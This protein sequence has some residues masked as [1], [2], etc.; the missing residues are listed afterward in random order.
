MTDNSLASTTPRSRAL[1]YVAGAYLFAFGVASAVAGA[2]PGL[3]PL[4]TVFAADVAA[5]VLVFAFS[6]TFSNSSFYD[7]FWSVAPMLIA[8]YLVTRSAL[9]WSPRAI[10]VVALVCFW[11]LRL[12]AN[13]VGG[14]EGL[15]HEDWRYVEI[16][17]KAGKAQWVASFFAIHFFPTCMVFLGC[18][19]LFPALVAPRAGLGWID[20]LAAA[21]TLGATLVEMIAD[22]QLHRFTAACKPGEIMDRG[23]WRYS[24]HPNYFG[25]ISFWWGLWL[26]GVAADP[27]QALWTFAGPGAMTCLFVFASVPMLDKRSAERRPGY[28]EHMKR[29]SALVP[30]FPRKG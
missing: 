2:A 18:F 25:E 16:R 27:S 13:W 6:V 1:I 20:G 15:G 4:W 12:T 11:G 19:A 3:H 7:P 22:L 29:V 26:F 21:V 30:W 24:R 9:G 14:W 17:R 8:P 28:A 10:L 23:L 5:T